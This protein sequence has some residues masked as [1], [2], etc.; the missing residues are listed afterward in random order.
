MVLES[1]CLAADTSFLTTKLIGGLLH[2]R[3]VAASLSRASCSTGH[4]KI[5]VKKV[6]GIRAISKNQLFVS[7]EKG[8]YHDLSVV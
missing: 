1:Q 7:D 2:I 5:L 8:V 4:V 6:L 3:N